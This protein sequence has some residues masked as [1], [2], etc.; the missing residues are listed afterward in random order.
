M[1][2]RRVTIEQ[3][4][5]REEA[6]RVKSRL[7]W[8]SSK[9]NGHPTSRRSATASA[10]RA[11]RR[12]PRIA[13]GAV[14]AILA[15]LV[16][17]KVAIRP[18]PS[19]PASTAPASV[20]RAVA[21]VPR[22]AFDAAGV[23]SGLTPPVALPS[24]TPPLASAGLP[25]VVYEGAEYCPYCAAERWAVVVALSR[26][27]TFSGLGATESSTSD[28]Y[29]GTKTFTFNGSTFNSS[30][31]HFTPVELQSNQPALGGGYKDLQKP[32]ELEQQLLDRFDQ[33]PYTTSAGAIPFIDIGNRYVVSGATFSPGL[34]QGL[35]MQAIANALN[36]PN[37]AIAK[38]I[39]GSANLITAAVCE[40][41]G[42]QPSSVCASAGV[43]QAKA[44]LGAR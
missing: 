35:S 4:R 23:T 15:A 33:A 25:Q 30:Y 26:F 8:G 21:G 3:R 17:V 37:S 42:D 43:V 34:L 12:A 13:I 18:A 29:P 22:S 36:D 20:V 44:R 14:V 24:R 27:G 2:N 38:A 19:T 28:V 41:T 6:A 10:G 9:A 11:G 16:V 40:A 7:K 32:T 31:L 5:A 39:L 1:T